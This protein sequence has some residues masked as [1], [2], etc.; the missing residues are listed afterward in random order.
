MWLTVFILA[1]AMNFEATRPTLAPLML[2]RPRPIVQ[3]LAL[4]CGSFLMGLVAGLLVVFVFEQTPLGADRANGAKAQIAIGLLTLVIAAVM[5]LNVPRYFPRRKKT[6]PPGAEPAEEAAQRPMDK[7]A[8][9]AREVLRKGNSPWLSF[10]L[11]LGIGLPS[12]DF[13]AVLVVIASAGEPAPARFGALLMFLV[14]GNACLAIPLVT[15]LLAPEPTSR[16]I[17][18]FQ[19][20]IR[21]RSRREFAAV[22]CAMGLLQIVLGLSRL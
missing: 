5:A 18:R 6:A 20:W 15:Y 16:W 21:A 4:F 22:V 9:R 14:V 1:A 13:L 7:L 19:A 12:V 17:D 8:E 10:A 3:L 11:G 2:V